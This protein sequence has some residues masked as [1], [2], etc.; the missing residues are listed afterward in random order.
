M[1]VHEEDYKGRK[2]TEVINEQHENVKYLAG[3][4]EEQCKN[5]TTFELNCN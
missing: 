4:S 1:Y 5:Q 2:L 3:Q